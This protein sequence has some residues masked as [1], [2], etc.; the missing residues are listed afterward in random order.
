M[1]RLLIPQV[2]RVA[3]S[4]NK[5]FMGII[6]V[7]MLLVAPLFGIIAPAVST[8]TR[9]KSIERLVVPQSKRTVL[10]SPYKRLLDVTISATALLV[11]LPLLAIIAIAIKLDSR[12]PVIFTQ[13]RAGSKCRAKNGVNTWEVQPFRIFK[14]RTMYQNADQSLH[15]AHIRAY[16]SGTLEKNDT[17]SPFKLTH[18]PRITRVGQILRKTSLDELPQLF[19]VLRGEMSI[20]GPRPVPMYEYAEYKAWHKERLAALPGITGLWQ[21]KGRCLVNF[22]EQVRLD[23]DYVRH[24]SLAMDLKL[25]LMT[26]PAVLN[27]HGAG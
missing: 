8:R 14:F 25:I 1:K 19:N 18:D 12:G 17:D 4:R 5:S 20:V 7:S 22:D 16:T 13:E 10:Y 27:G 2:F 3:R 11:L 15:Q 24:Q 9:Q 21:V 6:L 26:V 23:I